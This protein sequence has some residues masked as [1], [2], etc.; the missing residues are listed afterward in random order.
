MELPL[1]ASLAAL[2]LLLVVQAF[3]T[4][5][6]IGYLA[7]SKTR[8]AQ[9][10]AADARGSE[11]LYC[12]AERP[13]LV[14]STILVGITSC[15]YVIEALATLAAERTL[16]PEVAH[17][18]ALF[19]TAVIVL[20]LAEVTPILYAIQNP[21]RVALRGA[22][23]LWVLTRVLW[24]VVAPLTA[25]AR[26]V[27]WV[28]S[29]GRHE[30]DP[31]MTEAEIKEMV[32]MGE[33]QG[34]LEEEERR[35]LYGVFRFT[36]ALV[37]QVM[38]ARTDMVC[39][40]ARE[41]VGKALRTIVEEGFTRLPVYSGDV[42]QIVGILY[43]K[44]LISHIR[45]GRMDTPAGEAVREAPRIPESSRVQDAL[46]QLQRQRR[47]MAIVAD[48][49]GGVA[50]L[51][52]LEDLLEEI[53][54]EIE[55]EFDEEEALV[56]E[57]GPGEYVCDA[58]TTVPE[59][60]EALGIELEETGH[61]TVGGLVY[62]LLGHIPEPGESCRHEGL[63]LTVEQVENRRIAK[64]RIVRLPDGDGPQES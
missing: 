61:D 38:V 41:P 58:R 59:L 40:E 45:Q 14:L 30:R 22:P 52:T 32:D 2:G 50:G 55:D 60:N 35:M 9:L 33:E 23:V 31:S 43:A 1:Y 64:V 53:V 27:S 26:G 12:L 6:E 13:T 63:E 49:Y 17:Y 62:E 48:E 46:R 20:V 24:V 54:G 18:V 16:P 37:G 11:V 34:V 3:F 56:R 42:D 8:A 36:D 25:I 47:A 29:G 28:L 7:V 10:R 19:G 51:V 5:S 57:T 44:D 21:E 4:A 15:V 39:V